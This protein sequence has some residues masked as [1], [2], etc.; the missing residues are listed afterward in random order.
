MSLDAQVEVA[1]LVGVV[2]LGL[3]DKLKKTE[4][5]LIKVLSFS[6]GIL[7]ADPVV[8]LT[9][10]AHD[11]AA[12]TTAESA[13]VNIRSTLPTAPFPP[14]LFPLPYAAKTATP[15]PL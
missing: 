11:Y 3:L 9:D 7:E 10:V 15:S 1:R 8:V 14:P 5:S 6:D 13:V 12:E 2:S 4:D